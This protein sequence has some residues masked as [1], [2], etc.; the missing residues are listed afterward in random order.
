MFSRKW[1]KIHQPKNTEIKRV[2][3]VGR[4]EPHLETTTNLGFK[5][6]IDRYNGLGHFFWL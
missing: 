4:F 6:F 5:M 1:Q 3:S 2:F